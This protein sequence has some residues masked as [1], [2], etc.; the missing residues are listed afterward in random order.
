MT[1]KPKSGGGR[2]YRGRTAEQLR[3]ER[4]SRLLDAA[5]AL[6]AERG[7]PNTPIEMLCAT[8][9]VT[10]RHFYEQFDGREA[11]LKAL[12]QQIQTQAWAHIEAAL[13]NPDLPPTK[14]V[15]A[16]VAAYLGHVL[17]DPRRA[18][19]TALEVV[20]VS[21]ELEQLRRG[22]VH[23]FTAIVEQFASELAKQEHLPSRD[24]HLPAVALVGAIREL[25]I[26][27]LT[28]GQ[29]TPPDKLVREAIL[30]LR[31]LLLGTQQYGRPKSG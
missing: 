4:R 21:Q 26:E 15:E 8:A 11:L 29:K 25:V 7:Y 24:Y 22:A 31:V 27:W 16:A 14:R 23:A 2:R 6:F 19:I 18:R 9:K 5:L 3:D 10:T 20:G 30:F 1:G 17:D 13:Q 12:Y 28:A